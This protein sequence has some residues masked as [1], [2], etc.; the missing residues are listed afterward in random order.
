MRTEQLKVYGLA[1]SGILFVSSTAVRSAR[2]IDY[3]IKKKDTLNQIASRYYGDPLVS[4]SIYEANRAILEDAYYA[5]LR[6]HPDLAK[7]HPRPGADIIFPGYTIKLPD[8]IQHERVPYSRSDYDWTPTVRNWIDR[9]S[10]RDHSLENLRRFVEEFFKGPKVTTPPI[11][12][13]DNYAPASEVSTPKVRGVAPEWYKNPS[14]E[15]QYCAKR[16]CD[17]YKNLCYFDCLTIAQRFE[18]AWAKWKC[19][20]LPE[21]LPVEIDTRRTTCDY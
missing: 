20:N 11:V 18:D 12:L 9:L 3:K 6:A 4:A 21:K 10:R 15:F 7:R 8:I 17:K 14:S 1:L 19:D 13:F 2:A 5:Q 16:V